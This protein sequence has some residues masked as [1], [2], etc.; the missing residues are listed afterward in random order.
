MKCRFKTNKIL[1]AVKETDHTVTTYEG[2]VINRKLA[3]KTNLQLSRRPEEQRKP[4]SRGL[5]CRRFSQGDF[6]DIHRRI[7]GLPSHT[8]EASCSY[9][10]PTM[11]QEK[12]IYGDVT[13]DNTEICDSD[14]QTT[15][16]VEEIEPD[17][18]K[19]SATEEPRTAIEPMP[20]ATTPLPSTPIDCSTSHGSRLT[21]PARDQD[22]A[23][24]Q[25]T[26]VAEKM[27]EKERVDQEKSKSELP[28][29]TEKKRK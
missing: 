9:T 7:L 24:I 23:P 6:C 27:T 21:Q 2:K 15:P 20:D 25:A 8:Q 18:D 29:L 5:R 17:G 12:S 26:V 16:Y 13:T 4:T 19:T 3:A 28:G 22:T 14:S 10:L 11:T 1:T